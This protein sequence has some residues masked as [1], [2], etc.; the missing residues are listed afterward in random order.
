LVHQRR[1]NLLS[2]DAGESE[3]VGSFPL[4]D[5]EGSMLGG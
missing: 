5:V 4:P 2:G 1:E 3:T